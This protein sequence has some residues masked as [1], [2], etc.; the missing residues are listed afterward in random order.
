MRC[1]QCCKWKDKLTRVKNYLDAFIKGSF[2]YHW[3]S[4]ADHSKS[5]QHIKSYNLE[6]KE[7][8]EKEG[9]KYKKRNL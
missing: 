2:N 5:A 8:C 7:I 6:E 9:Q 4:I 1:A 3:S